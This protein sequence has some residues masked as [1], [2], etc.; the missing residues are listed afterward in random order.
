MGH[1]EMVLPMAVLLIAEKKAAGPLLG[2][3]HAASQYT[4]G[5]PAAGRC[6]VAFATAHG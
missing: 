6:T 2:S 3:E 1:S 5:T 4:P